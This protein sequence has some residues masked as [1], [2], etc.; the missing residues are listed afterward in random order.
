MIKFEYVVKDFN[1][2]ESYIIF[3]NSRYK[4][5]NYNEKRYYY[6]TTNLN[7]SKNFIYLSKKDFL[8]ILKKAEHVGVFYTKF[9][10]WYGNNEYKEKY[11]ALR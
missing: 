10:G 1:N 6:T 9:L 8:N 2:E 11:K 3:K 4:S 7:G 5:E